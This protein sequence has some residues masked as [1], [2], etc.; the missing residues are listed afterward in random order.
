MLTVGL[1]PVCAV[2]VCRGEDKRLRTAVPFLAEKYQDAVGTTIFLGTHPHNTR[3]VYIF[4]T[5]YTHTSRVSM[6]EPW[7]LVN[8]S[9]NDAPLPPPIQLSHHYAEVGA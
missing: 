4:H 1:W 7:P 8:G 3:N 9:R 5:K 2:G 6:Q